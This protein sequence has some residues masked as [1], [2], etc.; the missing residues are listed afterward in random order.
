MGTNA[1]TALTPAFQVNVSYFS[2]FTNVTFPSG[3]I[4]PVP[5]LRSVPLVDTVTSWSTNPNVASQR[6][7][8]L[9]SK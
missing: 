4:R 2:G 7:R 8:N 9:Q 5:K 1:P 6:R 3:R